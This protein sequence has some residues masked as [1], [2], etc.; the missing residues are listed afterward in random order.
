MALDLLEG[1]MMILVFVSGY[2]HYFKKFINIMAY[3][4]NIFEQTEIF[5]GV[6]WLSSF[7]WK[8]FIRFNVLN[9]CLSLFVSFQ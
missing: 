3:Q 4:S 6:S 1:L 5:V 2:T 9:P 7:G 8:C